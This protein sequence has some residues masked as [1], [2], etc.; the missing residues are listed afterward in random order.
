MVHDRLRGHGAARLPP[1]AANFQK[2]GVILSFPK[3][4]VCVCRR[5]FFC[6]LAVVFVQARFKNR[7]RKLHFPSFL[8]CLNGS[9]LFAVIHKPPMVL[10]ASLGKVAAQ[11]PSLCAGALV[12]FSK[13]GKKRHGFCTWCLPWRFAGR[14]F[15][16]FNRFCN[17]SAWFY[18]DKISKYRYPIFRM[19]RGRL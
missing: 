15:R 13:D 1:A 12:F 9:A 16:H 8:F 11:P 2:A 10:P 4:S 7:E 5:I 3:I 17:V 19:E 6:N 18:I 14:T